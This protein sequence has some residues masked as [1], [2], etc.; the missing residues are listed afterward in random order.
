VQR[1]AEDRYWLD[2]E[3]IPGS[4]LI[5]IDMQ[6]RPNDFMQR[7]LPCPELEIPVQSPPVAE[8]PV[9]EV[10]V[11]EVPVAEV[12]EQEVPEQEVPEQETISETMAFE[13]PA[14]L[15]VAPIAVQP[16]EDDDQPVSEDIDILDTA[17]DSGAAAEQE[18][19]LN[20]VDEAETDG[21]QIYGPEPILLDEGAD[22]LPEEDGAV[23]LQ[24]PA[25]DAAENSDLEVQDDDGSRAADS[26]FFLIPDNDETELQQDSVESP[27]G[28]D[29]PVNDQPASDRLQD[30]EDAT[31]PQNT[32]DEL[33]LQDTSQTP[34]GIGIAPDGGAAAK[35]FSPLII[36]EPILDTEAEEPTES[37][38]GNGD[39]I[40]P[41][42]GDDTES[43]Q[44]DDFG[45]DIV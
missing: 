15:K 1:Q 14:T 9:A 40:D 8:V 21:S 12:P 22:L 24:E 42:A 45:I 5:A 2:Y 19:L 23:E 3:Q 37:G 11:A 33:L 16:A 36:N 44:V 34:D 10:P 32:I 41:E 35:P 29:R 38:S 6:D 30:D 28:F 39:G 17:Q 43:D 20:A 31:L 27:L 13:E 18:T 7:S 4:D 26:G 25:T